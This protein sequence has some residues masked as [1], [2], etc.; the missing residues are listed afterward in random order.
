[1]RTSSYEDVED[2]PLIWLQSVQGENV[3]VSGNVLQVKAKEPAKEL[4]HDEFGCSSGWQQH[5]KNHHKGQH[6]SSR[7][8]GYRLVE[9]AAW[10]SIKSLERLSSQSM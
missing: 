7:K 4:G 3:P 1:M 2:A 5:F 6:V 8:N 9:M 10:C